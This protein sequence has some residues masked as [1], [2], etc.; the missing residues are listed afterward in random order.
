[1]AKRQY[2]QGQPLEVGFTIP[3]KPCSTEEREKLEKWSAMAGLIVFKGQSVAAAYRAVYDEPDAKCCPPA[4]QGSPRF[5]AMVTRLRNVQGMSSDQVQGTLEGFYNSIVHD[6]EAPLKMR[7]QAAGQWQK[8]RGLEKIKEAQ[9]VDE[10]ELIF[11]QAM[12]PVNKIVDVE[13][14]KS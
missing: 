1:M 2:T 9:P 13:E 10:D 3:E 11:R 14:K 6:E 5:R 12:R 4:I 7:L 8:L